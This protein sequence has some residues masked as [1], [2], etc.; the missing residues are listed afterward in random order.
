MR[1]VLA[2]ADRLF[3][4]S[5]LPAVTR[6]GVALA[7]LA[8]VAGTVVSLLRTT[9]TGPLQSIWEEDARA[10]LSDALNLPFWRTI[11][12]PV[13]GY[14]VVVPRL[15]GVLATLFPLSWAAAVLSVSSAVITALLTVQIYVASGAHLRSKLARFLVS[16]PMLAAPVAENSLSEIYNRPVCLHFFATYALFWL[17]VWT[18]AS[19]LG[20]AGFLATVG[21]TAFSTVL[22]IGY[23]PLAVLRAG[24]RRDRLSIWAMVLT[25]AGSALQLSSVLFGA[26]AVREHPPRL[27]PLWALGTFVFWAV[28]RS[29]LGYRAT[30]SFNEA[31]FHYDQA[32]RD[33]AVMIGLAWLVVLAFVLLAVLGA[34]L[35]W[36]RP[37]WLLAGFAAGYAVWLNT[38]MVIANGGFTE[39]YLPPVELLLFSAVVLLL[40]PSERMGVMRTKAVALLAVF[41]VFVA[42]VSAFNYRY[43]DTYR[44]R[45]PVWTHQVWL[46]G[47]RCEQDPAL[48]QV[49]IR[50]GPQPF[51]SIVQVPC[52]LFRRDYL[53]APPACVYLDPPQSLGPP[54]GRLLPGL[55][56]TVPA[57]ASGG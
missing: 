34:R 8:V 49:V 55:P 40:L 39:R 3:P 53:C 14:Y 9:G 42:V 13:A 24:V 6:R 31:Y 20:K 18:P 44:A 7:V 30:I 25:L 57:S 23:A 10:V 19:R 16:A 36:V 54:D 46:A 26:P 5:V 28:P 12:Q 47:L 17:F 22:I 38:M 37:N 52:H 32:V 51:W 35:G 29:F 21:L 27:E 50:G 1:W 45:A 4:R 41:G 11:P 48:G 15:L 43:T 56:G 2:Q 33:H